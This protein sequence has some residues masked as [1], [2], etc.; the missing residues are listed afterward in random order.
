[1]GIQWSVLCGILG[2]MIGSFLNVVIY[3]FPKEESIIS[4]G[5]H[6]PDCGHFLRP[7]ELIPILS[8]LILRG[9]CSQCKT[10][11]PWRYPLLEG[12][13]GI[14][15]F[16]VALLNKS[17]SLGLLAVELIFVA[18][19]LILAGIDWYTF[20]LPDIFTIPLIIIGIGASF[21]FPEGPSGWE[22]IG[23]VIVA[24]GIFWLI[25]LLY[26]DGMGF[27]DV[28]LIMGIGAFLGGFKVF[29]AIFV[30]SLSGSLVGLT[31]LSLKKT[32]FKQA[33]PFGPYLVLG[34]LVSFLAGDYILD[35][36]TRIFL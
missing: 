32:T 8:Y 22:S 1:M 24:G 3:R 26:P 30:A 16:L 23:T 2:L 28:K 6:C 31:L 18:L 27:G 25:N 14:L 7:W 15:F 34:A 33:I 36:Y 20:R 4:P 21:F 11:I 13:T 29:L 17:G 19:L 9:R 10:R 35:Y 5:S 12:L